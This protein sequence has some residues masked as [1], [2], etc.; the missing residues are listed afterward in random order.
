MIIDIEKLKED[1]LQEY[2]GAHFIGGF[3]SPLIES[4]N[5]DKY[6]PE[7]LIKIAEKLG[8]NIYNYEIKGKGR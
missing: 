8:I 1:I 3:G 4:F 7:E 5:L 6:S 2:L